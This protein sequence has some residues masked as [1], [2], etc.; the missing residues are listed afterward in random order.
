MTFSGISLVKYKTVGSSLVLVRRSVRTVEEIRRR[1]VSESRRRRSP[2]Q[3]VFGSLKSSVLVPIGQQVA[4]SDLQIS[5]I[6]PRIIFKWNSTNINVRVSEDS[7]P[8]NDASER[9]TVT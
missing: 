7:S 8:R 1:I 6:F 5:P 4:I 3:S 2:T 9:K